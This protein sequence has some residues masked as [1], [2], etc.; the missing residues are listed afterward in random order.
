MR[1]IIFVLVLL[2]LLASVGAPAEPGLLP[3]RFGPWQAEGPAR[4]LSA[5]SLFDGLRGTDVKPGTLPEAGLRTEETRSYRN[6]AGQLT[7]SL[8]AFKDPSG[9]Y[10]FYT[11]I[12]SPYK[13]R[14][15]LG[16]ESA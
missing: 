8:L 10:E 5:Q 12:I 6:S 4:I 3:E 9:A 13:K 1:K 2:D 14:A 11:N 15:G 16:D 7:L